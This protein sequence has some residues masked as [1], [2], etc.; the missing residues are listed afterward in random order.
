[1]RFRSRV[2]QLIKHHILLMCLFQ[3]FVTV[4]INL[5]IYYYIA[6]QYL[7]QINDRVEFMQEEIRLLEKEVE[8][9]KMPRQ[10]RRA[11]KPILLA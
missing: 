3:I 4:I 2:I 8:Q 11:R 1:M 5:G 6:N 9:Q 10:I 7:Q